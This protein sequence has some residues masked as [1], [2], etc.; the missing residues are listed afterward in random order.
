MAHLIIIIFNL[1]IIIVVT[2]SP[3][4]PMRWLE[5]LYGVVLVPLLVIIATTMIIMAILS[6]VQGI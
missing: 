3:Y 2:A 1:L 6:A 5:V 4:V